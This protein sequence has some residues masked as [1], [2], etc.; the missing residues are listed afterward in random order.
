MKATLFVASVLFVICYWIV[1]GLMFLIV[2]PSWVIAKM[3]N[4]TELTFRELCDFV[5]GGYWM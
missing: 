2:F 3:V 4:A 5:I 1:A